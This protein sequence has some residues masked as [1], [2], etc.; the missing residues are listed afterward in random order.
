MQGAKV[1]QKEEYLDGY[2]VKILLGLRI[3]ATKN[4]ADRNL[5]P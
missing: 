1:M 2:S 3:N 4:I 5:Y